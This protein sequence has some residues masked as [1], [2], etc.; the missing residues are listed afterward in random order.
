[1]NIVTVV[2]R[3]LRNAL[4]VVLASF[5]PMTAMADSGFYI[6]G[7]LGNGGVEVDLGA[8][9]PDFDETD[10]A[11]KAILGYRFDMP[12]VFLSVEGGYVNF[13]EPTFRAGGASASVE[14]TGIN[15]FGVVGIEAGPVDLFAKAG[16]IQWDADLIADDGV[17]PVERF[18][19]DGSDMG[20][21]VGLSFGLGPVDIR[22]EYELYDIED[23]DVEMVS[24]GFTYLFD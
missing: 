8:G 24:I 1:M 17:N 9:I 6:G 7:S 20:Y 2:V 10:A 19:D 18:S 3:G 23:A 21:G 12:V 14:P 5:L 13:G 15:L 22:G 4:L 16:Y 11:W